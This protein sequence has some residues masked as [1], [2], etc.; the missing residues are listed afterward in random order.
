[1]FPLPLGPIDFL[2]N[3]ILI[4]ILLATATNSF[5]MLVFY[6]ALVSMKI[7]LYFAAIAYPSSFL[8]TLSAYK[9]NLLATIATTVL[10]G[11]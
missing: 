3:T 9:S 11:A 6:L 5:Y 10:S 4:L 2:G 7:A 1:L 8:T